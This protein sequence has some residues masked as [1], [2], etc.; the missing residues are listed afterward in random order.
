M[1]YIKINGKQYPC[2]FGN[3]AIKRF[4]ENREEKLTLTGFSEWLVS[5]VK[6]EEYTWEI[7]DDLAHLTYYAIMVGCK[8]DNIEFDIKDYEYVLEEISSAEVMY[9]IMFTL[10]ESF[11]KQNPD[12]KKARV[13]AQP[14]KSAS[15][16]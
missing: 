14:K 13:P 5:L 9:D 4:C 1:K 12:K 3:G 11:P 15:G 2:R 6:V 10:V 8:F 7:I 16:K